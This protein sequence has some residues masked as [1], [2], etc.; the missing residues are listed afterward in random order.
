MYLNLQANNVT[1]ILYI[2]YLYIIYN[3]I[4]KYIIYKIRLHFLT[5]FYFSLQEHEISK[6]Y[7]VMRLWSYGVIQP[8][9]QKKARFGHKINYNCAETLFF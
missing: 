6:C 2:I 8:K 3:I 7:E 1:L 9:E 5:T 4:Y